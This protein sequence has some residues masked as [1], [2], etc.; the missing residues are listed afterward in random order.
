MATNDEGVID[1]DEQNVVD[2]KNDVDDEIDMDDVTDEANG[3]QKKPKGRI[4]SIA[5]EH[6]P[7]V[8]GAKRTKCIY[9]KTNIAC[10]S[11]LNGTSGLVSHLRNTCKRTPLYKTK[12]NDSKKQATLSF[13]PKN[14]DAGGSLAKHS[15]SQEKGRLALARMY[16]KDNRPFSIVDDEGFRDYSLE[17]NPDFKMVSRWTPR[18]QKL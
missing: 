16:I 15:F 6:F 8:K 4:R 14:T 5:W 2:D 18:Q 13:K 7:Y 3:Q 12:T 10:G 1:V 9:C 17:L 11:R